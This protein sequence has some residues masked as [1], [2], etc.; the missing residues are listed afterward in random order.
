MRTS[1]GGVDGR[2]SATV[3]RDQF[4]QGGDV[5]MKHKQEGLGI[6]KLPRSCG[7]GLAQ[8]RRGAR[9]SPWRRARPKSHRAT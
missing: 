3:A 7:M 1:H 8:V 4:S 2:K 6:C 9:R 5:A